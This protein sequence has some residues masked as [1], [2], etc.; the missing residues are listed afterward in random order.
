VRARA[1]AAIVSLYVLA[2]WVALPAAL[3]G[4]ASV[5]DRRLGWPRTPFPA[6]VT[7]LGLTALLGGLGLMGWAIAAL[8]RD[9]GGLPVSALPPPRLARRGPYARVR[10]PIYLGFS[11]ALAGTGIAA[12][13]RALALVVAPGFLPAW[14]AY[15]ALEERVLLRRYGAAY[16]RYRAQVGLLPRPG[17]Y[18][19]TQLLVRVGIFPTTVEGRDRVPRRGAAVLVANHASYLDPVYVGAATWRRIHYMTT[20]EAYRSGPMRRLVRRFA[21]VPA[22]RYRPDVVAC[23]EMVRLLAEGELVGVFPETERSP[24]GDYRGADPQV[25]RLLARLPVPVVPIGV[26]G[27]YDSGPRWSGRVRRRPVRVRV[28]LPIRWD[29]GAP[30]QAVDDALAGLVGKDVER[31]R[32]DGLPRGRLERVLWRCPRCHGGRWEAATLACADCGL[33]LRPTPEGWLLDERDE[34]HSLASLGRSQREAPEPGPLEVAAS[35]GR[36]TRWTGPLVPLEPI[37]DGTLRLD[38]DGLRFGPLAVS[39]AEAR[40]VTVERADTLQ[41][42]TSDAMWQF[43]LR[44]GSV[45]RLHEAAT[46]WRP[47]RCAFAPVARG[48]SPR[49]RRL[50][51]PG[52]TAPAPSREAAPCGGTPPRDR[53]GPSSPGGMPRSRRTP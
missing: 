15:A 21:N 23:R 16:R 39:W 30:E 12:G 49:L 46:R 47:A 42:A 36:E 41:V 50:L 9:A 32:L 44:A 5:L 26:E 22:R 53:P 3:A 2:F 24:L 14:L 27:S 18:R 4:L 19:L 25:A 43:R 31:V 10:H 33:R 48:P 34:V 52:T 6:T 7:A 45:F 35:G 8:W 11:L 17:L 20:A 51:A 28:G 40:S 13:S 38:R 37:G 29:G 1:R